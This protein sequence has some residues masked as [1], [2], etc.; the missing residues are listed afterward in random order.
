MGAA[1]G[2]VQEALRIEQRPAHLP[3]LVE[4]RAHRHFGCA[5]AIG[6]S[7]HAVHDGEHDGAVGVR[8]GDSVLIFFAMPDE[9]QVCVLDLQGSLR[10]AR[11]HVEL[12]VIYST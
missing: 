5:R 7:A 6:V 12:P 1:H 10:H 4:H 3:E 9:A 11:C 8:N 2:Q